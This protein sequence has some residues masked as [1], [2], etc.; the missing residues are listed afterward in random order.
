MN[1]YVVATKREHKGRAVNAREALGLIGVNVGRGGNPDIV[2]I[3]AA[4][5]QAIHI[6]DQ[7]GQAYHVEPE[8]LHEAI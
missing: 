8:N 7:I 2:I 6:Q 5:E 3:E 4:P 1:R